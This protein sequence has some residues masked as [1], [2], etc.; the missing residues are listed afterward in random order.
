M[1]QLHAPAFTRSGSGSH[2]NPPTLHTS[3]LPFK[4]YL[5]FNLTIQFVQTA[6]WLKGRAWQSDRQQYRSLAWE[7]QL[8]TEGFNPETLFSLLINLFI[9][10]LTNQS[11]I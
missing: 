3:A 9:I 5:T 11:I 6:D 2:A 4:V 7:L 8:D 1:T 10:F